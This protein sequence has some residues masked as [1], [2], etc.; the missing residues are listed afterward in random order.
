MPYT[1]TSPTATTR[2][3]RGR[4]TVAALFGAAALG[5][6]AIVTAP[7]AT[8][9]EAPDGTTWDHTWTGTGV[10]VYVEEHGDII[11]VCDTSANGHSA[12]V[13][14]DDITDNITGY[15]L[16]ASNGKGTCATHSASQGGRYD[17]RENNRIALNYEGA[18]G[19]GTYAVSFV[20]DH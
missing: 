3:R 17:L 10:A 7:S 12:W 20:N 1:S 5:A 14:V 4:R 15:K 16:T 8:A 2:S 19:N 6:L 9:A 18:G 11:S 13:T